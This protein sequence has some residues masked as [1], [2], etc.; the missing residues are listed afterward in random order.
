MCRSE[1]KFSGVHL[2]EFLRTCA[3]KIRFQNFYLQYEAFVLHSS[4]DE[5]REA[6]LA[7]SDL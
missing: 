2:L 7:L 3:D 4:C 6:A 5:N 1:L